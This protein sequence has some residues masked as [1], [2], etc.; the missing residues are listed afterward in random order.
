MNI[1]FLLVANALALLGT[2]Y[3]VPG[4]EVI[5]FTTALF[6]AL[7]LGLLNTFL[8]PFLLVLTLP[9]NLIT[10]GLFSWIISAGVLWLTARVVPGFE[11]N[12]FMPALVGGV[13]LAFFASLLHTVVKR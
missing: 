11:V 6:A 10:F 5:N 1:I 13:V 9:V 7:V 12:G 2:A 3:F 4:I 8:R